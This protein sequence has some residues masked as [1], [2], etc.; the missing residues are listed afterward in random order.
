MR[1]QQRDGT[2]VID[3]ISKANFDSES[4][5]DNNNQDSNYE[6]EYE[7]RRSNVI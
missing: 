4:V 3:N 7:S 2:R 6:Q 5:N 1:S